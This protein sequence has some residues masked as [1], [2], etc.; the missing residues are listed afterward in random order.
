MN[1]FK[2]YKRKYVKGYLMPFLKYI[3]IFDVYIKGNIVNITMSH[4][5]NDHF[6]Q[7][8]K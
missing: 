4:I 3:Y 6:F 5:G 7:C 8:C 1:S 2:K